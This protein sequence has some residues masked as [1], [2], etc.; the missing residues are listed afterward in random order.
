MVQ[1]LQVS[2]PVTEKCFILTLFRAVINCEFSKSLL[3]N[4]ERLFSKGDFE[5]DI[6]FLEDSQKTHTPTV[7]VDNE[8]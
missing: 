6:A 4:K 3:V 8:E 1:V 5:T 2:I 7:E